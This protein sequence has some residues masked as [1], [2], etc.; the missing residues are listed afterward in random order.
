MFHCCID[1]ETHF[2]LRARVKIHSK[3]AQMKRLIEALTIHAVVACVTK[4][5]GTGALCWFTGVSTGPRETECTVISPRT[6][7]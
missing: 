6:H 7:F 3:R 4:V 2:R 5:R 1:K